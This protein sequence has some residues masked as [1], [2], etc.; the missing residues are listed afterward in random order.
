MGWSNL[1]GFTVVGALVTTIGTLIG[2]LLKEVFLAR[3]FE[4]WKMKQSFDQ[5]SRKY[6]EPIALSALELFNRLS[7][8]CNQYP[9][10]LLDSS[11][12]APIQ[13]GQAL[14][15]E[16]KLHFKRYMLISTVYRL[17]AFLG[18]IELYRQDMTFFDVDSG[19]NKR[20]VDRAIYAIR[21]DL[22]DARLNMA[23]DR[24][25][26]RDALLFREDQRAI[27]ESM[28][29]SV[30]GVRTVMGYAEFC[31]LFPSNADTSREKW[32]RTASTFLLD[33][34]PHKDFREA[35]MHYLIIHLVDLVNV[36]SSSRLRDEHWAAYSRYK[37][38]IANSAA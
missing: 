38:I 9:S 23:S 35:R 28:I 32:L 34:K 10:D 6:K 29:I 14:D 8:I 15:S 17:C 22:A 37:E 21:S 12:L 5:V 19:S 31:D 13:E 1:L 16:D 18:W 20:R 33:L 7:S 27:G 30:G 25:T 24:E 4:Q 2:L 11:L 26:W 3:S 36:V